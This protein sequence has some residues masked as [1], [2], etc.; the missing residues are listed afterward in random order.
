MKTKLQHYSGTAFKLLLIYH[1]SFIIYNCEAQNVGIN[2]TGATAHASAL[3]DLDDAGSNNKGL[4]IPRIPLTAINAAAPVTSPATSL[5]VYNTASASTG[6]NAVSPGYYYWDG[7]KWVRFA[8]NA[9]GSSSS[10]WDLLGNAG[11]NPSTNF[12]GTTDA[13]DLVFRTNNL[14]AV[15]ITTA[16]NVGI[17]TIN[18]S[19]SLMVNKNVGVVYDKSLQLRNGSFNNLFVGH[20]SLVTHLGTNDNILTFHTFSD[21]GVIGASIPTNE[22]MRIDQNGNV[23]IGTTTPT[24]KLTIGTNDG[25]FYGMSTNVGT[26]YGINAITSE[27]IS[28][29]NAA[30]WVRTTSDGGST[31]K[32]LFRV[33]NDGNVAIGTLTPNVSG[34]NANANVLTIS[35]KASGPGQ[36][37]NGR[38]EL[39][40]SIASSSITPNVTLAGWIF[41]CVN[42]NGAGLG[43]ADP[44]IT[45]IKS[46]V[47]GS[48]GGVSGYGGKFVFGTK[49]DNG[50]LTDRMYLLHNGNVGIGAATPA[51]KLE[52]THGTAG[53]SGLRFTNLPNAAV[54]KTDANGDVVPATASTSTNNG[55]FWGLLGNAGTVDGTNF[56]GTTDNVPF[57]IKVNNQKAGKID[58]LLF[59]TSFGYESLN[60]NTTGSLN[61]AIGSRSLRQN[62]NGIQ[63]TA[64]GA[65]ALYFNTASF[66]TAVGTFALFQNTTGM[67]NT[68]L[69]RAALVA[70]TTGSANVSVGFSALNSNTNGSGNTVMGYAA[71]NILT[72]GSENVAIGLQAGATNSLITSG[73]YNTFLG[74]YADATGT[75]TNATAIGYR[76]IVGASNA[77]VLGGTGVNA[78]N[79]GIGTQTPAFKLHV[80]GSIIKNE[81]TSN[82]VTNVNGMLLG[83]NN[84]AITGFVGDASSTDNDMQLYS[85]NDNIR[86]GVGIPGSAA[87]TV[88]FNQA[89]NLGIGTTTPA[90][91]LHVVGFTYIDGKCTAERAGDGNP[92]FEARKTDAGVGSMMTFVTNGST[93]GEIRTTGV[94][95]TYNTTSDIRLKEN[96]KLSSKGIN[97]VMKIAVK[98]YNY[99]ADESKK[100][101][102]GF[103]AQELYEIYPQAVHKGGDDA[104]TNPWMIDY[105]KLTPL[106]IKGMQEQQA[107]IEK[108][109]AQNEALTK[110][111]EALEK[112]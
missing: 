69:G 86:I 71:L 89:G 33:Q 84:G 98:D 105:S 38:L 29:N 90:S 111:I 87:Q 78:V 51:N 64:I 83:L 9:S 17:G 3:L 47:D 57:N 106:L 99:K 61:I 65:D 39:N 41:G 52:I 73:S 62:I 8:Y 22:R 32:Q 55:V 46:V 19:A 24:N 60:S 34:S 59:N 2:G 96:I 11:T 27:T 16:G 75:Y 77:L 108:L 37:S 45:S 103:I 48:T 50:T 40:N 92:M 74:T 94:A 95:T 54:L 23:G 42:N 43:S 14:E 82:T 66:N 4:L 36:V 30:L 97:D 5:L 81:G 80:N 109:N 85:Y 28:S 93:T 112:K 72:T 88:Y 110:R 101:E 70:N 63:N 102:T 79:V 18:P 26:P 100:T 107:L 58:N 7:A 20:S 56:I 13:Q 6:T 10:A 31:F 104:K 53:N 49:Q 21:M 44:V 1:L 68:A 35:G 15:R 76:A 12:L 25:S 91:K 67:F